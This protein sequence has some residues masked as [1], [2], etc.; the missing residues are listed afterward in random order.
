M[1]EAA[2]FIVIVKNKSFL[3]PRWTQ[4]LKYNSYEVWALRISILRNIFK[5]MNSTRTVLGEWCDNGS[6]LV[7]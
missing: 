3:K 4:E 5:K 1:D 6:E 2:K 7:W